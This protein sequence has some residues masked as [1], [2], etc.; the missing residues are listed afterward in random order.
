MRRIFILITLVLAFFSVFSQN[1][2]TPKKDY[3]TNIKIPSAWIEKIRHYDYKQNNAPLLREFDSFIKPHSLSVPD[4]EKDI[5]K[6]KPGI[7]NPVFVNLDGDTNDEL[8]SIIG[9]DENYPSMAVFKKTGTDWHLLYLEDFY[10]FYSMPDLYVAN[11]FSR[12][13]TFYFRRVYQRGSGVYS[14]G[15]SFY[16]LINN[17]VYPCLELVNDAH[18]YGWGLY[19]NQRVKMNFNFNGDAGDEIWANYNYSFFPGAVKEGD[20]DWCSNDDIPLI[21]GESGVNYKWDN[22]RLIY[23]LDIPS[24]KNQVDD[25]NAA[26]I[27]CFGAFAN[28]S[29]FV[30]AFHA[31]IN[32]TLKTGTPKQKKILKQYLTLVKKNKTATTHKMEVKKQIGGSK[33]YGAKKLK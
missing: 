15:Y 4:Y 27:S 17:K 16:K 25:L 26:K 6:S 1:K 5:D 29:L 9:W 12:N 20:C 18:I 14:D 33:F 2:V 30:H 28:D 8:V 11:S 32:R 3:N 7:L 10:M 24:Y 22:K 13:K 31:E 23:K 19:L 21:K